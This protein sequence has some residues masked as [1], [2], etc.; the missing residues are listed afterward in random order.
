MQRGC[1]YLLHAALLLGALSAA[2]P[3]CA[4]LSGSIAGVVTD[5]AGQAVPEASI[6]VFEIATHAERNVASDREGAPTL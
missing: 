4:Q 3:A 6:R 1:H 2:P 5:P